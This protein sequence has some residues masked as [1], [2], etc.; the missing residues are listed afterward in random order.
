MWQRAL[1][2]HAG[3]V[4]AVA[5]GVGMLGGGALLGFVERSPAVAVPLV[6]GGLVLCALGCLVPYI[7]RIKAGSVEAEIRDPPGLQLAQEVAQARETHADPE[8][9]DLA[10]RDSW[11]G[12]RYRLGERAL[13]CLL[14]EL[15]DQLY[16]CEARIFL[17]DAVERKLVPAFRPPG[18]TGDPVAWAPGVGVVGKA[19]QEQ[20]YV[21]ALGESTHDGTYGLAPELHERFADLT[22]VAAVPLWDREGKILGVLSLSTKSPAPRLTTQHGTAQHVAL[23]QQVSVTLVD[24]IRV[25]P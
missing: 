16:G 8:S 22:A 18:A 7:K 6:L 21:Y 1:E 4:V 3:R 13:E 9:I 10:G 20:S 12:A 25:T 19:F 5:V 11:E 14:T 2:Q 15:H 17:F 24:L 23:A